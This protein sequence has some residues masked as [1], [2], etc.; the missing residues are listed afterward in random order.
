MDDAA[1]SIAVVGSINMDLVV[2]V[3][4]LPEPGETVMGGDLGRFHGGKGANQAVAA[5]RLGRRVA[6]V[7]CVGDDPVGTEL[8]DALRA[9]GVDVS[10]VRS[11]PGVPSGT[12]LIA[13]SEHGENLIVVSPGANAR[14]SA[15]LVQ[16][17]RPALEAAAV[18]L[19]Q[20]EIPMEAVAA[21]VRA[22]G[23]TTV[24]NPAP[25]RDVPEEVLEQVDVLVPNRVELGRMAWMASP[26]TPQE[27]VAAVRR[28]RGVAGMVVVTL[29]PQ[30][31]LVGS[32]D[33]WDV[34]PAPR[35]NPV[36]TTAA[37]DAFCGALA[38]ALATGLSI[39]EAVRWATRVAAVTVTRPGAQESMPHRAEVEAAS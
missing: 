38:D 2:R 34:V 11:L 26:D 14:V 36:D 12:A 15:D 31:A 24:L 1:P 5:A 4:R 13:V 17:A 3:E 22:A 8:V 23:G 37:G 10:H 7:G 18:T 30:G 6:F 25:A 19:V 33:D 32:G 35:V 39:D 9:D 28:L 20:L 16:R 21:T 27:A 29:G